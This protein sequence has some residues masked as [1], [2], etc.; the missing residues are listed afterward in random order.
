MFPPE[1]LFKGTKEWSINTLNFEI[2]FLETI[3]ILFWLVF[4]K[5]NI[6]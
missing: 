4:E 3:A 6:N 1:I 5:W 2:F